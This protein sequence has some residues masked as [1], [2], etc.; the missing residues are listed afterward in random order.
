MKLDTWESL[1][2]NVQ[3]LHG[4]VVKEFSSFFFFLRSDLKFFVSSPSLSVLL[5]ISVKTAEG[6]MRGEGGG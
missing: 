6:R 4:L 2:C 3:L 5:Y 1:M